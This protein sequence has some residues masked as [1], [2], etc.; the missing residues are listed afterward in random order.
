MCLDYLDPTAKSYTIK[1]GKKL[2]GYKIFNTLNHQIS[3]E[4]MHYRVR[5]NTWIKD[6]E[7]EKLRIPSY[8]VT[9]PTGFHIYLTQPP[10]YKHPRKVYYKRPVTYGWQYGQP[11][12]VARELFIPRKNR[13]DK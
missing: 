11:I 6:K 1:K 4:S 7:T 9:Y 8:G 13:K 12:V 2:V 10:W 5:T 3:F